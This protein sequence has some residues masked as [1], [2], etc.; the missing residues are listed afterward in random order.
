MRVTLKK[1]VPRRYHKPVQRPPG[2]KYSRNGKELGGHDGASK[3]RIDKV[4]E[5][6]WGSLVGPWNHSG[7]LGPYQ[8]L[9]IDREW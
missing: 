2:E 7:A 8:E 1:N 3:D 9:E 4:R 6:R 5:G